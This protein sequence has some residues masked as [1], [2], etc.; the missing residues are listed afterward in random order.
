MIKE[1]KRCKIKFGKPYKYSQFQWKKTVYCSRLCFSKVPKSESMR[2]K[3]SRA[4]SGKIHTPESRKR[5]SEGRTGITLSEEHR[6][7]ISI[8]VRKA[9][10]NPEVIRKMSEAKRGYKWSKEQRENW[11][12]TIKAMPYYRGGKETRKAR[13]AFSQ[14]RRMA[15]KKGNGGTHTLEEWEKLKRTHGNKCLCCGRQEPEVKLTEDHVLP[16]SK[17]GADNIDNIQPLCRNCNSVKHARSIDY[18]PKENGATK[19][20]AVEVFY[21]PF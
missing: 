5:M 19:Q 3:I 1:C 6:K 16:L 12:R 13:K 17:G 15:R 10:Q 11:Y 7:N 18:R 20:G 8:R 9:F 21:N 2:D 14:Q 4:L